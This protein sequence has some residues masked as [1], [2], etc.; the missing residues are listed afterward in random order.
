MERTSWMN[1]I[2]SELAGLVWIESQIGQIR[3]MNTDEGSNVG[4]WSERQ[5]SLLTYQPVNLS[6]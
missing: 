6:T 3:Q 4:R 2:K 1:W 5:P